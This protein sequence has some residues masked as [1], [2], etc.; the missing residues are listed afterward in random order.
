MSLSEVFENLKE[1][2]IKFIESS[3]HLH[4]PRLIFNRHSLMKEGEVVSEPW[5]EVTPSYKLGDKLE[6]L[7]LPH[8]V[9]NLLLK[10]NEERLGVFNPPYAHQA[11][12]LKGFFVNKKNLIISTGTGSGKTEIFL[13]SILGNLAQEAE[14]GKTTSQRAIRAIIL[15]PMNALVADQLSRLRRL[16]GRDTGANQMENIFGRRVQ[17]G[18]YTGRTPYHGKYNKNRNDKI[19]KPVIDYYCKLQDENPALFKELKENGRV[20]AKDLVK[21]RNKNKSKETQYRTQ[22]GDSELFTRQEMHESNEHG[23]AP[24]ILITNYSMLEYMLL[25]PIEQP[26]FNQTK[27]WLDS[28][29]NNELLIVLDEAHMYRGAQGAEVALLVRRL[30]QRLNVQASRVRF[31]LTSASLGS[32]ER[33]MEIAPKF[34]ASLTSASTDDFEVIRGVKKVLDGGKSASEETAESLS[35]IEYNITKENIQTLASEVDW[36][37]PQEED[38]FRY[39]GDKLVEFPVFRLLQEKLN[40]RPIELEELASELFPKIEKKS[41]IDAT[42]NLL[43]LGSKATIKGG[44]NLLPAR[45]HMF[46]KGLPR[47]FAC[48][49][50]NCSEVQSHSMGGSLMGR[51]YSEPKFKC[52][53]GSRIFELLSHRTCGAAYIRG[54]FIRESIDEDNNFLWNEDAE[55]LEEVHILLEKPRNDYYPLKGDKR[56]LYDLT[57]RRYLDIET[58]YLNKSPNK[59]FPERFIEVWIPGQELRTTPDGELCSWKRCPTCGDSTYTPRG[60][61]IMDLETKGEEPFANIVSN[62]FHHQPSIVG[63]EN[64]PNKGK[65]AL[66]FSDSRR[67]TAKL[68]RDLQRIVEKDS[69][70]EVIVATVESFPS[71]KNMEYLFPA[72]ADYTKQRRIGFFDDGDRDIQSDG[73]GY[74]GSRTQFVNN[75]KEVD[76]I[77]NDLGQQ[78]PQLPE[79]AINTIN[80]IRPLQYDENILRLLGHRYFSISSSLVGFLRPTKDIFESLRAKYGDIDPELINEILLEIIHH[81]LSKQAFDP[82]IDVDQR[83]VARGGYPTRDGEEGLMRDDIIPEYVIEKVGDN[84]S[85]EQWKDITNFLIYNVEL[86]TTLRNTRYVLNPKSVTLQ[87]GLTHQWY[88]CKGCRK[89]SGWK[90]AGICPNDRCKGEMEPVDEED[91]HMSA[92]NSFLRDPCSGIVSGE[93]EPFTLRS[94]EHS[95]QLN[96]KDNSEAFSKT[97]MYEL[98]FQDVLVGEKEIEQPIDVLSCTTTMEVGIDIGSLTAVA[99]RTVPPLPENYQQR[100]GRAGRRGVGLSTIITFSDNSPH[101]TYYFRNPDLMI[102]AEASEPILY[103]G[104]IKIAERHINASLLERFFDPE[105]IEDT[106]DVF[107]SLGSSIGFFRNDGDY[108]LK[109]F[110]KWIKEKVLLEGSEVTEL[111]GEL[112]PEELGDSIKQLGEDWRSAF[113]R[114]TSKKFL[115]K[116]NK[117]ANAY[118]WTLVDDDENLLSTLLDAALLPTFSFPLDVCNFVV[119]ELERKDKAQ[120]LKTSYQMGRGMKEALSEY[121]PG[122]QIIVDKKTFTSYGLHFPFPSNRFDRASGEDWDSLKWLNFCSVCETVVQEKDRNLNEEGDECKIC[123]RGRLDSLHIYKPLGFSPEVMTSGIVE[124]DRSREEKRV[125]AT[126]AEFPIPNTLDDSEVGEP[127]ALENGQTM[128]MQ[129]QRLRVIN[130]GPDKRGFN[131]CKRCG[132]VGVGEPLRNPHNRPYPKDTRIRGSWYNKCQGGTVNTALGY[133]FVTDLAVLRIPIKKPLN[134]APNLEIFKAATKSLAEALV[135]GA[136]RILSI[137]T[138]ELAGGT[139]NLMKRPEDGADIYGYLEFFLYDTTPGGAGFSSRVHESF[140]DVLK[141]TRKILEG[142]TCASSC[143]SCLRTYNN[144]IWHETMDR[145]LGLALLDYATLGKIPEVSDEVSEILFKQLSLALELMEPDIKIESVNNGPKAWKISLNGKSLEVSIRSWLVEEVREGSTFHEI[146]DLSIKKEL[147]RVTQ[148]L[149]EL[150]SRRT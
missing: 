52:K 17:F 76:R 150:L 6:D 108:S 130:F 81:A 62:L 28:D 119:R 147:P 95:A 96:T 12:A 73:S 94:E 43:Y 92:R 125:Y 5:V 65:K 127:I 87:I 112:L 22:L 23:G 98:L 121:I 24:D 27:E 54:Y 132:A 74:L 13:W 134:F 148:R 88:R 106:A 66:C 71:E 102:G 19:I 61:N 32:D 7:L 68:A 47:L 138:N 133:E 100:S 84:L 146:P 135:I 126:S 42:G 116:L 104:N 86:F 50:P 83:R 131:I 15:Y 41:A 11:N 57:P 48:L 141:E 29:E 18:M 90:V 20:P 58:G 97:E 21:F 93:R 9:T 37:A 14:R 60:V 75:Q 117:M 137:N 26:M 46:F 2:H 120:T 36:K 10:F 31:I 34:A 77:V 25:R 99:M 89:F 105:D 40:K 38:V 55:N 70:R 129:N 63:K 51:I 1:Q 78:L 82:L 56:S 136:S 128:K 123:K 64:L 111:L 3:Y 107:E 59:R 45:L 110:E 35:K 79:G 80:K 103:T 39:L 30:L 124:E 69:F 149:I 143:H 115:E 85:E 122:R 113:I 8:P 44:Q 33:A 91:P 109:A 49:N 114:D 144:R 4:H 145:Y 139:R 53:C 67:K 118:D 16:I 101:E 140:M 142:C 72:F